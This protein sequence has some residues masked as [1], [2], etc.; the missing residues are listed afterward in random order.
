MRERI[1]MSLFT[2]STAAQHALSRSRVGLVAAAAGIAT[3]VVGWWPWAQAGPASSP[4][5]AATAPGGHEAPSAYY[6]RLR[7]EVRAAPTTALQ[8][9]VAAAR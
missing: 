1:V 2:R 3:A 7:A 6:E 5:T 4:T 8:G 9:Y